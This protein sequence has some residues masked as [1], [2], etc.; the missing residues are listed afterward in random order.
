MTFLFPNL[1]WNVKPNQIAL[2]FDDGPHPESTALLLQLLEEAE[3]ST[4]HFL[5]GKNCEEFSNEFK[6]LQTSLH[7]IGHH[8]YHH[9]NAW[10]STPENY[11]DDLVLAKDIVKTSLFRP[12]YGRMTPNISVQI[13]EEFPEIK[14]CQFNLMPGDFD[15]KVDS[16]ILKERMYRAKGGDII[17]LHDRPECFEKYAPFL[18]EWIGD[19]KGKGLEF[20]I[21]FSNH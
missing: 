18:K 21:L 16:E 11:L 20:V 13:L 5:I 10:R 4:T 17:V 19:M 14:I 7:A 3:C 15:A 6:L 8:T 9:L 1:I 2:T 12:P